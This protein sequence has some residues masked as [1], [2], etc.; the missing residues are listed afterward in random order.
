VIVFYTTPVDVAWCGGARNAVTGSLGPGLDAPLDQFHPFLERAGRYVDQLKAVVAVRLLV[1]P[2][3]SDRL[4]EAD[5]ACG[6][7]RDE[8]E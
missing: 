4:R 7:R 5:S 8:P 6:C 1:E 3:E 2:L